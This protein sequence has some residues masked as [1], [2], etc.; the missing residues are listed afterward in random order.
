MPVPP[1]AEHP[2]IVEAWRGVTEYWYE[3]FRRVLVVR[4]GGCTVLSIDVYRK[5]DGIPPGYRVA[6]RLQAPDAPVELIYLEAPELARSLESLGLRPDRV[7]LV[8]VHSSGEAGDRYEA[9]N[10][11]ITCCSSACGGLSY[12]D[13]YR[14]YR[15]IVEAVEGRDPEEKPLRAPEPVERVYMHRLSRR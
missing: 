8:V 12:S 13:V 6:G 2:S 15:R 5:L 3:N 1:A 14:L 9:G 11:R 4:A 10:V 7:E